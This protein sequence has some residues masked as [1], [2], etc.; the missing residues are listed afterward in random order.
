MPRNF[1]VKRRSSATEGGAWRDDHDV[2]N[3]PP[4]LLPVS[5]HES[6][7]SGYSAPSPP[8]PPP[9]LMTSFAK[10]IYHQLVLRKTIMAAAAKTGNCNP[11]LLGAP[12]SGGG[13]FPGVC[14]LPLAPYFLPMAAAAALG[15]HHGGAISALNLSNKTTHPDEPTSADGTGIT[16]SATFLFHF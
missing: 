13:L 12:G 6:P 16:H 10:N 15:S 11:S 3:S 7:D 4:L 8:P 5:S 2:I 9:S 14:S 1:L